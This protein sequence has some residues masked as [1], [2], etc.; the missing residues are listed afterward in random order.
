MKIC[1]TI[2]GSIKILIMI[3]KLNISLGRDL[4]KVDTGHSFLGYR[5]QHSFLGHRTSK[6]QGELVGQQKKT[7][8]S[9]I[10]CFLLALTLCYY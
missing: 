4:P 10:L 6:E 3:T 5:T 2:K 9:S 1:H 8:K 7:S